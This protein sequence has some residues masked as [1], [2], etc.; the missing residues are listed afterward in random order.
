LFVTDWVGILRVYSIY[1]SYPDTVSPDKLQQQ[2]DRELVIEEGSITVLTTFPILLP[3]YSHSS[4]Y[5]N[6]TALLLQFSDDNVCHSVANAD[7]SDSK[8]HSLLG[9]LLQKNRAE[10]KTVQCSI[11]QAAGSHCWNTLLTITMLQSV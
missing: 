11:T 6:S 5:P 2:L 1:Y 8:L 3:F 9:H 4:T 10:R 7:I